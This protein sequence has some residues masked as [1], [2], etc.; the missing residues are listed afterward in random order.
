MSAS[1]DVTP[2]LMN[3]IAAVTESMQACA[4]RSHSSLG[5]P[6]KMVAHQ[7]SRIATLRGGYLEVHQVVGLQPVR[8]ARLMRQAAAFGSEHKGRQAHVLAAV[9]EQGL[10][11]HGVDL[12]A[13]GP[14]PGRLVA[15]QHRL[16]HE[17][18]GTAHHRHFLARLDH[19]GIPEDLRAVDELV[20]WTVPAQGFVFID[21]VEKSALLYTHPLS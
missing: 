4:A 20:G 6:R 13:R 21:G 12:V 5:L 18:R 3:S 11:H 1:C 8:A 14:R 9:G 7:R 10:V 15:G 17:G 16:V 2:G 19:A